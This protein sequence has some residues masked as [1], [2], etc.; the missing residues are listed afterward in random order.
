MANRSYLFASPF[1]PGASA[2]SGSDAG[3]LK[4]LS[5]CSY[6][7]PLVYRLLVSVDV[8]RCPS[9]IWSMPEPTALVG[10]AGPGLDR[11]EQFLARID[12][13]AIAPMRD[14]ALD[15]LNRHVDRN[16]YLFL[17]CAEVLTMSD[18]SL[19][20]Q[21]ASLLQG[22]QT[23]NVEVETALARLV[24]QK[25]TFWDRIFTPSQESIEAP[26]RDLGLGYWSDTLYFSLNAAPTDDDA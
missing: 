20:T 24:P 7:I 15:F 23:I 25:K 12:H 1:V 18:E 10:R 5:E 11:L 14:Q 16:G 6:N 22:V 2:A 4:G 21:A 26:L 9:L 13:P 19:E 17:E 3:Q 8:Q